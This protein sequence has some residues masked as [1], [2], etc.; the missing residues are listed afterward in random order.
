M[1]HGL[2]G[3]VYLA[4]LL[5]SIFGMAT[6]DRRFT[7][8]VFRDPARGAVTLLVGVVFFVVW[9]LV[10]IDLGIFFRGETSFMTGWQLY[11]ELPVEEVFFLVLLCWLTMNVHAGARLVLARRASA[12]E[13]RGARVDEGQEAR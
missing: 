13:V 5:F 4:A 2:L 7:L 3:F 8:F 6:L 11:P 9:D 12:A 1:E 10:G